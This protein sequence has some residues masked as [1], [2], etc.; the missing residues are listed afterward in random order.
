[1]WY[2]TPEWSGDPS[3]DFSGDLV[4]V[5]AAHEGTSGEQ[6][7][8]NAKRVGR[9]GGKWKNKAQDCNILLTKS[10]SS[11]MKP[12]SGTIV[13]QCFGKILLCKFNKGIELDFYPGF[14][15]RKPKLKWN[16]MKFDFLQ[17]GLLDSSSSIPIV[18]NT[19]IPLT[20]PSGKPQSRTTSLCLST[21][22]NIPFPSLNPMPR[23]EN[24]STGPNS[25]GYRLCWIISMFRIITAT[26][27]LPLQISPW[28][29]PLEL[30][31]CYLNTEEA[32]TSSLH[33]PPHPS[34]VVVE[35]TFVTDNSWQPGTPPTLPTLYLWDPQVY[36]QPIDGLHYNQQTGA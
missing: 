23:V 36:S 28:R 11:V 26:A 24:P 29:E 16:L 6:V 15:C 19:P 9:K 12:S 32:E 14:S 31:P 34:I 30:V 20:L 1:M 17:S 25:N 4:V 7:T 13:H 10:T 3:G 27:L 35:L 5:R 21:L 8:E 22:P 18:R 33:P 2:L